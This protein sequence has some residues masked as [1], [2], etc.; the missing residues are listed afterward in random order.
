MLP[1][2][3]DRARRD[4]EL[5]WT[6]VSPASG[7]DTTASFDDE[8]RLVGELAIEILNA[9]K[10]RFGHGRP[11]SIREAVVDVRHCFAAIVTPAL[12]SDDVET[13]LNEYENTLRRDASLREGTKW[14]YF[15]G[16]ARVLSEVARSRGQRLLKRNPFTRRSY[17]QEA[18]L[19]GNDL[20]PLIAAARRDVFALI[21]AISDPDPMHVPFIDEARRLS[22]GGLLIAVG[23][24]RSTPAHTLARHWKDATGLT[25]PALIKYLYPEPEHLI[26]FLIL[27][28]IALAANPDSLSYLR[29]TGVVP[30]IHP[31]KGSCLELTL[32]KYR[33][34]EIPQYLVGDA[35]SLSE[36]KL[37][38]AVLRMTAPLVAIARE[39]DRDFV[40]LCATNIG[41][42]TPLIGQLRYA[43]VRA[44]LL[45][46]GLKLTTLKALRTARLTDEWI[47]TR[48]PFRV[49]RLSGNA[50]LDVVA[51]YVLRAESAEVD[52]I[53]I[54]NAQRTMLASVT[55][56]T[57]KSD[58]SLHEDGAAQ[59]STHTC[60]DPS[61][62][63]V[64][65]DE[66]G[67]CIHLLWPYN[68]VHFVL[69]LEP[70]PVAFLLRD[71]AIL[72]EAQKSL[73]PERFES[74]YAPLKNLIEAEYLPLIDDGLR[75]EANALIP[76]LP[77]AAHA[78]AT[79]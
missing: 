7:R 54:A 46:N 36:G 12:R 74:R 31:S 35:G 49:W 50:S 37:I 8:Y 40:F 78:V 30:L 75:E 34:G 60:L 79:L 25:F 62:G 29:R 52:A 77:G 9:A 42:V 16:V 13:W 32:E 48:D 17:S 21:G 57:S 69:L 72:Q 70:R 3:D 47:R 11:S 56:A 53:A 63:R 22:A 45:R 27:V 26:P 19:H 71:Y 18:V 51:G 67:L 61:D 14:T 64:P 59:L 2:R 68:D 58:A 5:T 41:N 38:K 10:R 65:K 20:V 55:P 66:H 43:N 44:Y 4:T 28:S 1:Q 33:A 23:E 24:K 15:A 73:A 76:S 39:R 6:Y